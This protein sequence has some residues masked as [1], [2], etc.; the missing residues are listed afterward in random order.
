M[1]WAQKLKLLPNYKNDEAI[2]MSAKEDGSTEA[3]N[4]SKSPEDA[5]K[6]RLE[7]AATKAQAAFRGRAVIFCYYAYESPLFLQK[8]RLNTSFDLKQQARREFRSLKGLI[9]LQ[10]DFCGHL[11]RRQV[12]STLSRVKGILK[13]Q[14]LVRH[15]KVRIFDIGLRMHLVQIGNCQLDI[16]GGFTL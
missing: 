3:A 16:L 7:Q 9:V 12:V 6:I 2:T 10:A 5:E 11:V 8:W 4:C 13:F 1:N 14:T 15:Q